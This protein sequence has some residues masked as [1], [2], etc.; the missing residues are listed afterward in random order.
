MVATCAKGRLRVCARRLSAWSAS[1][2][3]LGLGIAAG[4]ALGGMVAAG[5]HGDWDCIRAFGL[6]GMAALPPGGIA[7][8]F[9]KHWIGSRSR[10]S[11]SIPRAGSLSR[12]VGP[13]QIHV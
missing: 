10:D 1:R 8:N 11:C 4:L 9:T 7:Q 12:G 13:N 3:S 6:G 2:T 5:L